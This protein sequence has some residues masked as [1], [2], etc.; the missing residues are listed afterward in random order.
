VEDTGDVL[1]ISDDGTIIRTAVSGI[2]LYGRVTQGVHIMT[3]SEGVKV[4]SLATT[5]EEEEAAE[6]VEPTPEVG[7]PPTE[8]STT[9]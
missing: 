4:I 9:V 3:V 8:E 6:E 2:N 5:H 7:E 1:M